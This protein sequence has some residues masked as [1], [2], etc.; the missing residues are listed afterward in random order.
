MKRARPAQA[1]LLVLQASKVLLVR[2]EKLVLLVIQ[3]TEGRLDHEDFGDPAV[4]SVRLALRVR[5]AKEDL[6][7]KM[8]HKAKW[9]KWARRDVSVPRVQ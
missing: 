3:E 8:V 4:L 7:V 1:A 5:L 9:V 2:K 6:L